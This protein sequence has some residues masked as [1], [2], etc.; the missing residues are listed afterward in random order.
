MYLLTK[1]TKKL[2]L[3]T[4]GVATNMNHKR[5]VYFHTEYKVP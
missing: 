3:E 4:A 2:N 5:S 1:K